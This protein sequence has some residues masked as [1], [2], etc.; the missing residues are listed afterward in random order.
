MSGE[1]DACLI[2]IA[3]PGAEDYALWVHCKGFIHGDLIVAKHRDFRPDFAKEMN[4]VVG[5]AVKVIDQQ[6]HKMLP[7]LDCDL[8]VL[9]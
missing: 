7:S 4:E 3:R 6:K 5:E 1:A 9:G 8:G 2:G